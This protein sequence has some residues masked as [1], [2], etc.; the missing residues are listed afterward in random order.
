MNHGFL[1]RGDANDAET[2]EAS[3]SAI[4]RTFKFI[5]AHM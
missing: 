3:N 5:A 2:Q 4:E 1:P